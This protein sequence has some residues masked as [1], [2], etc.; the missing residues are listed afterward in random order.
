MLK[1]TWI[2]TILGS[3]LAI[4]DNE[5][6]LLLEFE[7]RKGLEKEVAK[8]RIDHLI[9]PGMTS[10]L[11]SI[12]DELQAYFEGKLKQFKTPIQW[13]GTD[14]QK[15]VWEALLQVPFGETRSYREQA[16]MLGQPTAYRAVANA[17]GLN[18]LAIIVPCHRIINTNG[19]LGGYG[20]GI[21]WKKWLLNHEKE[22]KN[23]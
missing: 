17:N 21:A 22:N 23:G 14:F 7:G 19:N 8:L 1:S 15:R 3:M 9:I 16:E 6:L 13:V 11:K 4:S 5:K 18:Q 12:K 2:E 10:P 20:G